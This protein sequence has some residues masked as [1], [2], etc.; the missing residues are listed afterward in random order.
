MGG[1]D[2]L[3]SV[4][5]LFAV[6]L[7]V[8]LAVIVRGTLRQ[9]KWGI[10]LKEMCCP[11]CGEKSPSIRKPM[12]LRQV[13]WGGWTCPKCGCEIDKWGREEEKLKKKERR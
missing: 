7:A 3:M 8:L 13:L 5:I 11:R 2:L 1:V 6:L 12:S 4:A 9:T 10:N